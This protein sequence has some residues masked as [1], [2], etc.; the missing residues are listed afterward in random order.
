M[1]IMETSSRRPPLEP[2]LPLINVVFLLL[3][4]F[5]L[6]GQLAKR[7][8]VSVETPVSQSANGQEARD[9]LMLILKP[10]GQWFAENADEPLDHTALVA[11]LG[12][13]PE[14][15]E[16]RLMADVGITM[17][18]LRERLETLQELGVEQVRLVT[19]SDPAAKSMEA[20]A[21]TSS[22]EVPK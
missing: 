10:D 19:Q 14:E 16:V 5:M 3:I 4:F 9:K 11:L 8:T 2:V 15:S 18:A 21:L 20:P 1:M 12:D 7:P 22:S 13:N 6:A 17:A